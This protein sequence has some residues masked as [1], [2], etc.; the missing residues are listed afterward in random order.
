MFKGLREWMARQG[1]AQAVVARIVSSWQAGRPLPAPHD[2]AAFAQDGYRS[3]A[4]IAACVWEIVT[5]AAEPLLVAG[6]RKSDGTVQPLA[7]SDALARLIREPNPEQSQFELLEECWTHQQ[8]SGQ[9]CLHKVRDRYGVPVQLWALRPD[10]IKPVPR[11]DGTLAEWE[12]AVGMEKRHLLPEDIVQVKLHPDPLEDFY[13]LGPI[14]VLSRWG[15]LDNQAADFLR[16]F[17]LNN[18]VP[19]GLLKFKAKVDPADRQRIKDMWR[20]EHAGS[21]GWHNVSVLDSDAEYQSTGSTP[22]KMRVD[23]ITDQSESRICMAFGVPAILV[24]AN[25]GL[26]RST[27]ANYS[28]AKRSFWDET[29]SPLYRRNGDALTRGLAREFGDDVV[30]TFDLS[31]VQAL[32]DNRDTQRTFALAAWA[33]G[34]GTLDECRVLAGMPPVGGEEGGK[35]KAAAS[36]GLAQAFGNQLAAGHAHEHHALSKPQ[37]D[38]RAKLQAALAD[39]FQRQGDA[40]V[41]HLVKGIQ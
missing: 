31:T 12:Y 2:Y 11:A 9:F 1:P 18:G 22:D 10:R 36:P 7:D 39:H 33:G 24:G 37:R 25:V 6:R 30:L 32:Q 35:R 8:V 26:K 20:S 16:A 27:F 21:K 4:L 15:D 17:F 38:A 5:S 28:E 14:A 29:L 40:L 13:G 23:A 41:A 19:P 34:L 3:N